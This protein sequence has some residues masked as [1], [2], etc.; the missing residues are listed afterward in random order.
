MT[1]VHSLHSFISPTS[2]RE[3]NANR[4]MQKKIETNTLFLNMKNNLTFYG[5]QMHQA[6]CFRNLNHT[7]V[8][9]VVWL[10][11]SE[12][13]FIIF[14]SYSKDAELFSA[15]YALLW[16][17]EKVKHGNFSFDLARASLHSTN[18]ETA[19]HSFLLCLFLSRP[20]YFRFVFL[21]FLCV[22]LNNF[23]KQIVYRSVQIW[24]HFLFYKLQN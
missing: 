6:K 5:I 1:I 7:D 2:V 18:S 20:L 10:C 24:A 16:T 8:T 19:W 23:C 14:Y 4:K 21:F 22:H 11:T 3:A 17:N 12:M 9:F 13:L 15:D